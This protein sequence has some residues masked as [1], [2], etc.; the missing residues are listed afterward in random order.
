[1]QRAINQLA[2]SG[3]ALESG[4]VKAAADTLRCAGG[5]AVAGR[6]AQWGKAGRRFGVSGCLCCLHAGLATS[7]PRTSRAA[8]QRRLGSRVPGVRRQAVVHRGRQELGW[9]LSWRVPG[10]GKGAWLAP[11]CVLSTQQRLVVLKA[12]P[13]LPA[14]PV[15][16]PAAAAV[17]SG[18][19]S[20]QAAAGNGS[21]ADAK[22]AFVS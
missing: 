6:G 12:S 11:G 10:L 4:D 2:Q 1:M 19:S 7:T 15:S 18:L 8:L 16:L 9:V 5:A 22:K 17:F 14:C 3:A 20:L 21:A 13:A